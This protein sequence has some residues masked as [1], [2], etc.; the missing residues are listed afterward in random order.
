[1]ISSV[2]KIANQPPPPVSYSTIKLRQPTTRQ[3][4]PA[5]PVTCI[6]WLLRCA[7]MVLFGL[8]WQH[9]DYADDCIADTWE[10]LANKWWF[11]HDTFEPVV[12]T[13]AFLPAIFF[14]YFVD[15]FLSDSL[16]KFRVRPDTPHADDMSAWKPLSW[17]QFFSFT[18]FE[19]SRLPILIA[20]IGPLIIVDKMYPRRILPSEPPSTERFLGEIVLLLVI[21]DA[22]FFVVH[23]TLHKFP[24]LY[25][26]VH[27][28]HH[29]NSNATRANDTVR[30]TFI[31]EF[32][33]VACSI[34]GVNV[35]K[36]HPLSRVVY[37]IIIVSLLVELHCGW[38]FS[39]MLHNIVPFNLMGGPRRHDAHHANGRHYFQKFFTYLDDICGPL[40]NSKPKHKHKH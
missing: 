1:M 23:R 36:A 40:S 22:L 20:Y 9:K 16:Q 13:I 25:R 30:L 2:I 31:E 39:W 34:V 14:W 32:L 6:T 26:F 4:R 11:K 35:I 15:T 17:D 8:L 27:K 37:N 7:M 19:K 21:Y 29:T 18:F 3:E 5:K 33:D 28:K 38:D 10:I 12:A 24:L